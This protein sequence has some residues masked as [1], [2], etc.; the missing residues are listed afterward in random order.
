M[1]PKEQSKSEDVKKLEE[2]R[3]QE[4]QK[5]RDRKRQYHDLLDQ[6]DEITRTRG[7]KAAVC[8]LGKQK[9]NSNRPQYCLPS[10][11]T[12]N[13]WR[14]SIQSARRLPQPDY[15]E[16]QRFSFTPLDSQG[17]RF[18]AGEPSQLPYFQFPGPANDQSSA[19][20]DDG[21]KKSLQKGEEYLVK[22]E[23]GIRGFE[24]RTAVDQKSQRWAKSSSILE[25]NLV[26][27]D[28]D[29]NTG[30]VVAVIEQSGLKFKGTAEWRR[31]ECGRKISQGQEA[32]SRVTLRVTGWACSRPR[33]RPHAMEI[34]N[35]AQHLMPR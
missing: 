8:G 7:W 16:R 10:S 22:R 31:M 2:S 20:G 9:M 3:E 32:G 25:I 24:M 18:D 14:I 29:T 27:A 1:A 15:P 26:Y 4:I 19:R 13:F 34:P 30:G 6:V 17:S 35:P 5:E 28:Q 33:G 21:K 11:S 23:R 12:N